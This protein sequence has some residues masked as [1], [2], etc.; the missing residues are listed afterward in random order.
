MFHEPYF[1]GE[2]ITE[3]FNLISMESIVDGHLRQ[4]KDNLNVQFH[5]SK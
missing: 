1:Y 3:R 5:L 4:I 2:P